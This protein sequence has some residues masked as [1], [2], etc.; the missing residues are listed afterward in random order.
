VSVDRT[1]VGL[2]A[3]DAQRAGHGSHLCQGLYHTPSGDRSPQTAFIATHYSVDFAEHYLAEALASRGFGFLG[4]NT[5]FRGNEGYFLLDHALADIAIGARWL[6]AQGV[7]RLVL[8]GNSGGGSLMAAYQAQSGRD[9]RLVPGDLYVSLAAHPGRPQVLTAWMDASVLDEFDPT[10]TDPALDIFNPENGPPY[11]PDFLGSYRAA[12]TAR[13]HRI[14]AWA[15]RELERVR[16]AGFPDRVF[17]TQRTWADPRMVDPS[18]D[19]SER[20]A[21]ACYLGD[22]ARANRGVFG[23]GI[24]STIRTWLE[25]WSLTDSRCG[26]AEH[27]AAIVLP[28]LVVQATMDT[29]VFPSDAATILDALGSRDKQLVEL[30]GDHYFQRPAGARQALAD[31]LATWVTDR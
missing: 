10:K 12:Q 7:E 16:A 4:W 13:N 3:D 25:M 9:D 15:K 11:G 23:I 20:P 8:L 26:G 21:P 30:A 1:F 5:R 24:M 28:A 19:P 18:L 17:T 31:V 14:T 2:P 27:L 29:G 22:P 6:R